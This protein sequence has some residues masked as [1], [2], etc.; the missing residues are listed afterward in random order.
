M[1]LSIGAKLFF[2]VA[3]SAIFAT[4]L[5]N[6]RTKV[7]HERHFAD[8]QFAK[9]ITQKLK[10]IDI[11]HHKGGT[12][13]NAYS[14]PSGKWICIFDGIKVSANQH[15]I[16]ELLSLLKELKFY[17]NEYRD[18]NTI[19][20]D[21]TITLTDAC[22]NLSR[23]KVAGVNVYLKGPGITF[24]LEN[25]S[26]GK[27]L[28]RI[29]PEFHCKKLFGDADILSRLKFSTK[30]F[31]LSIIQ[32]RDQFKVTSPINRPMN[33]K[34]LESIVRDISSLYYGNIVKSAETQEP[35]FALE[36][37]CGKRGELVE[38]YRDGTKFSAKK[39]ETRYKFDDKTSALIGTLYSRLVNFQ[40]FSG[41]KCNFISISSLANNRQISLQKLENS[42]QWQK[43]V[44][45]DEGVTFIDVD[46]GKIRLIE[47]K[48]SN[49][50]HPI[51]FDAKTHLLLMGKVNAKTN[52]GELNFDIFKN[53]D[54][55]ILF[56]RESSLAFTVSEEFIENLYSLFD[57]LPL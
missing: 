32:S 11:V 22:D 30:T 48:I 9:V 50:S 46:S 23:L 17:D 44:R 5:L 1:R 35:L 29:Y 10:S 28:A 12:S 24:F 26:I 20:S 19:N 3:A 36:L 6:L 21:W 4:L 14:T 15:A 39:S 31:C 37:D 55:Y 8:G 25:Q 51:K 33:G 47:D 57:D 41:L 16:S 27:G 40:F 13:I 42:E 52:I 2:L 34:L 18:F 7:F 38:F 53:S 49:L 56:S 43:F 45:S 54:G